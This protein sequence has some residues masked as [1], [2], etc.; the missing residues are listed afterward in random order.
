[1]LPDAKKMEL[2]ELMTKDTSDI[3]IIS[4]PYT[5]QAQLNTVLTSAAIGT[6][7]SALKNVQL[8]AS[9]PS[10]VVSAKH[11]VEIRRIHLSHN[12]PSHLPDVSLC[13]GVCVMNRATAP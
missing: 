12:T 3:I 6:P 2:L 13:A 10:G 1:M 4:T 7:I 11:A 9:T 5:T 8:P